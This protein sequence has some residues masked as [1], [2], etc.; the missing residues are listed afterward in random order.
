[1]QKNNSLNTKLFILLQGNSTNV[2]SLNDQK[3]YHAMKMAMEVC[4][5][6]SSKKNDN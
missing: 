1:M 6:Q 4:D 5:F 2:D 3:D